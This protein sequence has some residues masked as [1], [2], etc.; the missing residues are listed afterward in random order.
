MLK[1]CH[2][3][4]WFGSC[5]LITLWMALPAFAAKWT[6]ITGRHSVDA[7]FVVLESGAVTLKKQDGNT[8]RVPLE[9]LCADDQRRAQDLHNQLRA[10]GKPGESSSKWTD[11]S[12]KFSAEATF[13]SIER[14]HV[15]LRKKDDSIVIVPIEKLSTADQ[16]WAFELGKRADDNTTSNSIAHKP[17]TTVAESS[18]NSEPAMIVSADTPGED[19]AVANAIAG[20]SQDSASRDL[21][22]GA[23]Q[24]LMTEVDPN[25]WT[26]GYMLKPGLVKSIQEVHDG[27]EARGAQCGV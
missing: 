5:L 12:G 6:D 7:E 3:K 17:T 20:S 9:K 18:N 25:N 10:H 14:G 24:P 22:H 11:V 27:R 16:Q 4:S 2:C 15:T 23:S 21:L 1:G 8:V 26:T 13:I 19:A